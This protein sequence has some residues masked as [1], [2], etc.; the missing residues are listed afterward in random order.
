VL[1]KGQPGVRLEMEITFQGRHSHLP[2]ATLK[3]VA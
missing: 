3:R 2:V 1:V